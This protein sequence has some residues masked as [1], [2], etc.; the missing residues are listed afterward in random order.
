MKIDSTSRLLVF[1]LLAAAVPSTSAQVPEV[2]VG[3][4]LY[5]VGAPAGAPEAETEERVSGSEVDEGCNQIHGVD[6]NRDGENMVQAWIHENAAVSDAG[7]RTC[8]LQ[9]WVGHEFTVAAP[10][11]EWLNALVTVTGHLSGEW[12][13]QIFNAEGGS[14]YRVGLRLVEAPGARRTVV[15]DRLV[16]ERF[17][18]SETILGADE[19]FSFRFPA[20]LGNGVYS[21][22]LWVALEG[23]NRLEFLDFGETDDDRHVRYSSIEVCALPSD[24]KSSGDL[25]ALE[26]ELLERRCKAGIWLPRAAGGQLE[27]ARALL[28]LRLAQAGSLDLPGARSGVQLEAARRRLAEAEALISDGAYPAAC[29]SLSHGV[30]ALSAP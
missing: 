5:L 14:S 10:E 18:Q 3:E 30:R 22:E 25:E 2:G 13:S 4:C 17:V 7:E 24:A 27:E 19:D 23:Q 21:A 29:R 12:R 9:G 8:R 16:T 15:A 1:A 11:G 28:A 26:T 6:L 20:L